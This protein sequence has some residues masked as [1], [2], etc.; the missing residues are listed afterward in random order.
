M[1]RFLPWWGLWGWYSPLPDLLSALPSWGTNCYSFL[2][3]LSPASHHSGTNI[4]RNDPSPWKL[5][6]FRLEEHSV[7][8]G[9]SG[10][11]R[12]G[13]GGHSASHRTGSELAGR[14]EQARSWTD[15][16]VSGLAEGPPPPSSD[17]CHGVCILLLEAWCLQELGSQPVME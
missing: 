3:L 8:G 1:V 12:E 13:C 16:L 7:N 9:F 14:Q 5:A 6:L 15:F 10:M 17:L 11:F 2:G 4:P